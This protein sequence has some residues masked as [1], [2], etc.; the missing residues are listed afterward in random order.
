MQ[1]INE[2]NKL[3]KSNCQK[4]NNLIRERKKRTFINKKGIERPW[5]QEYVAK[6]IEKNFNHKVTASLIGQIERGEIDGSLKI[7]NFLSKLYG[8]SIEELM[9]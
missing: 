9:N 8:K 6:Q 2:P 1:Q 7:I 5:T 3:K 4:R